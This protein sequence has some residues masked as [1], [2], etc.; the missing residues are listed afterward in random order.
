MGRHIEIVGGEMKGILVPKTATYV[1]LI[2]LVRSVIGIC[3]LDK[4]IVMRYV[5]ETGMPPVR[6]QCDA[7]VKFYIQ[8]EK[9]D[10]HV[11]SKFPITIDVFDESAAEAMTP[12][13]GESNH[14]DVQPSWEGGQSDEA[15]QPVNDSNLIILPLHIPSPIVGL[16]LH[17]EYGIDKQHQVLNH[18][19]CMAHDDCNA[20]KLNVADATRHSNEKS[21]A[22]SIGAHSIINNI[23][24]QSDNIPSSD[25]FSGPVVVTDFTLITM[26]I[27][28]IFENKKLL[29]YHLHHDAMTKHYQF[30]VK[31]SNSTL[32]HVIC[33]DNEGC[34]WQLRA[35]RMRGSEFFVVKRYDDVHTCSIEIVQGHHRQAKS[36]MIG[37]CVKTKYLDPTNT[38]YRP[39]KIMR[40]MQAEFGVSFNYLRAW[41]G[42]EATLTSLK[43]DDTESYKCPPVWA[44]MVKR[45]NLGSDIHIETDSENC[46]KY[47][48]MCL[49]ASKHGWPYCRPVIVVDGSALKAKFGGMLLAACGHDANGSIFPLAFANLVYPDPAFG[50]CV[51]HLAANLKTRYKDFKGPLKTYFDGASRLYLLSEHN[52]HM[53][54]IHS[55][56]ADMHRYLVHGDPTKRS[57]AYSSGRRWFVQRREE[58]LKITSKLAPNAEKLIQTNFSLGLT[59][60]P[61]SANQFVYSVTNN[62]AQIF[63]V[64]MSERTCICKRF[65]VDQIPCPHAMAI[66]HPSGSAK[67]WDVSEEIRLQIVCNA[68]TSHAGSSPYLHT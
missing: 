60:T 66:F 25:S 9:K 51:Q 5:V 43:G 62:A 3:G 55:R 27:N 29:Q 57:C 23:R 67:G 15:I 11:L 65:Q 28:C 34:P 22:P 6:I 40:D 21:F 49:A 47:F 56:N 64:D 46:F 35:T 32:L 61:R 13:V 31:K 19:L 44:E 10:V 2:E 30:K 38:S 42:K 53:E 33:I 37:E 50:I 20:G 59:V 36:L 63:I 41:R 68:P 16:D 17:N 7:D 39:R 12:D 54:S 24:S 48:Y 4:T 8:L 52:R 58:A 1:S 18:D 14:I 45:K 26:H